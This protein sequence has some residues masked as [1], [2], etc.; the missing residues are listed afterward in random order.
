[1]KINTAI[2]IAP[3]C[4]MAVVL[5]AVG[6]VTTVRAAGPALQGQVTLRPLT[7]Q[8][9]K[10][11]GL[12]NAQGASGLSAVGVGQPAYLEALVNGSKTTIVTAGVTNVFLN[13]VPDADITNVSWVLTG[14]PGG[15]AAALTASPLGTNVPTYRMADRFNSSGASVYKVAGRTLLLPDVAGQYTVTVTIQTGNSGSTNLTQNITAGTYMGVNTCALCHSGGVIAPDKYHPWSETLH[16]T[17]FTKAID[18]LKSDHYSKN[19]IKCHTVGYDDNTNAVNGG[20][21][22]IA[23]Q[24]GWTFPT[25]L[26][27][28]NWASMQTNYPDVANL[29]NIQCENCHGPG[30]EHAKAL[31]NKNVSNWP[32]IGRSFIAG[33]CGQCHDSKNNHVK[34]AEWNNSKHAVATR[35]P[36]GPTRAA[37]ARCHTGQGFASYTDTLGTTNVWTGTDIANTD[38]TAITCATCHDP[39]DV[40]NPHQLRAGQNI[41]LGNGASVTNAGL[42]GFCMNCHQ[43][44]TGSVTNSLV[45]YPLGQ[46]TF[47]GGSSSFGPHDNPAADMLEGVNGYTYGKAIPSAAHRYAVT[48]TCVGCHMQT[49]ASTD[50]AF[51]QAGGHTFSMTYEVLTGGVTNTLDKVDVCVKCHGPITSFDMV[52][53]DYNNDG[54]IEGVQ[55]EVQK[56]LNKLSTLLPSSTYRADGNYVAD[57]LV[58]SPSV[59]TNWPA[60]FLQAAWNFQFVNNDLSKGVHNAP[61]AT[62]LLMASIGD[63]TGD[64]NNDGLADWWQIQYFGSTTNSLASPYAVASSDGLPNWLKYNLGLNPLIPGATIPGGFVWGPSLT[65]PQ[66]TNTVE[67]YTAAEVTFNTVVGTT[68]QIQSIASLGDTWQNVG[69]SI[70][71]TGGSIS[72]VTPTRQVP[73]QFFRVVHTP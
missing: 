5:M 67:I 36:S 71:G 42:G 59:K 14:K 63:L 52:R 72:Y 57:G 1:M 3:T 51:L 28:G 31:G 10:D 25:N 40:T 16:A 55:T 62:G 64:A 43:S 46:P 54:V 8:D 61:Y 47:A 39:H 65:N 45:K 68:Y 48:N 23:A 35:T 27:A 17:F 66:G 4:L 37:C 19:C 32:R 18:G 2:K 24:E 13:G 73:Q 20:F 22:D 29:A 6:A 11:Y 69:G 38:Y 12:T 33:N 44:R 15:S 9:V 21:D 70:A 60:K 58:K 49:V 7:P 56:L 34:V 50:P 30:S 41:T 53:Q 26:V